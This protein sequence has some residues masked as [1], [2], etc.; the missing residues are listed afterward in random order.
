MWHNPLPTT[1]KK[2][3]FSTSSTVSLLQKAKEP[4][5]VSPSLRV[6]YQGGSVNQGAKTIS[7]TI[8]S[9][10]MCPAPA[11]GEAITA[12]QDIN[13]SSNQTVKVPP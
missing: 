7:A 5:I 2:G 9:T 12:P 4:T 13:E 10:P 6:P 8:S 11:T 1:N 3:L